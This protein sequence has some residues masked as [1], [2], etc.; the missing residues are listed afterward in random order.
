M[1]GG[2]SRLAKLREYFDRLEEKKGSILAEGAKDRADAQVGLSER[3]TVFHDA[4]QE[5]DSVLRTAIAG[6]QDALNALQMQ[7]GLAGEKEGKGPGERAEEADAL[8]DD[9][10]M[11]RHAH[12]LQECW[13]RLSTPT[14]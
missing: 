4:V 6:A 9:R 5:R 14:L 13:H 7:Q 12:E 3:S 10:E 1:S 11:A 8:G 2:S